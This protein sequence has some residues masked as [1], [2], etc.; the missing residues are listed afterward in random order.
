MQNIPRQPEERVVGKIVDINGNK[1]DT[2]VHSCFGSTFMGDHYATIRN[3]NSH[4]YIFYFIDSLTRHTNSTESSQ[5]FIDEL[6]AMGG[7]R[8]ST[9]ELTTYENTD[10]RALYETIPTGTPLIVYTLPFD[11]VSSSELFLVGQCIRLLAVNPQIVLDFF[12]LRELE[13]DLEPSIALQ[14]AHSISFTDERRG[15]GSQILLQEYTTVLNNKTFNDFYNDVVQT[16]IRKDTGYRIILKDNTM[17]ALDY[18]SYFCDP[19]IRGRFLGND[20][21][22]QDY[23]VSRLGGSKYSKEVLATYF[24]KELYSKNIYNPKILRSP[25]KH[26]TDANHFALA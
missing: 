9:V 26:P 2:Y 20:G 25:Y 6:V 22:N 3:P 23:F 5:K 17:N 10:Y 16:L 15:Q 14:L 7:I 18:N 1:M 19:T 8:N 12:K 13:P 21:R 11:T 24:D 4:A